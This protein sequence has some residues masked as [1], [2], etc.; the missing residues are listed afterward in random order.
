M[1]K[2]NW[3]QNE[4]LRDE[5]PYLLQTFDASVLFFR[6]LRARCLSADLSI[7]L[8]PTLSREGHHHTIKAPIAGE[9]VDRS[10]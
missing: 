2:E 10:E 8:S 4:D 9:G 5:K 1:Q 3:Y 7:S 6:K